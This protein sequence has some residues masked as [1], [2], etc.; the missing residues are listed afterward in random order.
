MHPHSKYW[1]LINYVI[2]RKRDRQ[3]EQITKAMCG[4]ECWTDHHLIISKLKLHIQPKKRPQGAKPPKHL[5]VSKLKISDIKQSFVDTLQSHLESTML[6]DN[7]MD[8]RR[9]IPQ[10]WSVWDPWKHK[11]WFNENCTKIKQLLEEKCHAFIVHI[12]D[13]KSTVKKDAL[14]KVCNNVQQKLCQLQDSWLSNKADEI[15][16]FA[17]TNNMKNFYDGL[18]EVYGPTPS[19]TSPLLSAD[20]STSITDKEKVLER[21]AEHFDIILNCPPTISDEA[22]DRLPQ[23]PIDEKLD[24]IP[25]FWKRLRT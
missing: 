23:A 21:W 25:K 11:D 14:W 5:S 22:T 3:D 10:P 7:D 12:D 13:P 19:G 4:A 20:G 8:G 17:D 18:K 24:A 6:N 2:S 15:Q 16:G 9:C 1:Y